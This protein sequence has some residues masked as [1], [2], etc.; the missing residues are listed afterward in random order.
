VQAVA[1]RRRRFRTKYPIGLPTLDRNVFDF[2]PL[3]PQL[4][5]K[6]GAGRTGLSAA[7]ANIRF[8]NF[9]INGVDE[10]AV[11]GNVSLGINGGKS[12]P[13]DAVKEY[14]LVIAPYDVR[15]GDFTGALI[16]TVTRSGTNDMRGAAFTYWRSDRLAREDTTQSYER[17]Q[18]G[19]S[20]GGAI[21]RNRIHFFI[22]P[23]SMV[24]AEKSMGWYCRASRQTWAAQIP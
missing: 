23:G 8:N 16:N 4:S 13:L 18:T 10:R 21:R 19:F 9:L 20:L 12:V 3:A 5:T 2:L 6:V 14:Q 7:G 17:L 22:A 24:S 1:E 11:N 15:Y